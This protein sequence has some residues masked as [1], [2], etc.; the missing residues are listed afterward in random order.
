MNKV[1]DVLNCIRYN[2]EVDFDTIVKIT[3]INKD[4]VK[5]TLF[6]LLSSNVIISNGEKYSLSP[7]FCNKEKVIQDTFFNIDILEEHKQKIYYL[8][9]TIEKYWLKY[10][11]SKPKRTQMY[12]LIVEVNK[13]LNLGLPVVWYKFGQVVPVIF[14][15]ERDYSDYNKILVGNMDESKIGEIVNQNQRY[16]SNEMRDN[17]YKS[18]EDGLY[19]V[20]QTKR[21]MEKRLMNNDFKYLEDNFNIYFEKVPYFK[22]DNKTIDRFYELT[23]DYNQLDPKLQKDS[24]FKTI[25]LKAFELFWSVVAI[26]NFK[27]DLWQYYSNNQIKKERIDNCDLDLIKLKDEFNDIRDMFYT[28]FMKEKYKDDPIYKKLMEN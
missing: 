26:N 12:K 7:G 25:Y 23:Q 1:V 4:T 3:E 19:K 5:K 13:K 15:Q 18:G 28:K 14:D 17:Q 21:E 9:Y 27:S 16:S 22:D 10:T 20:Y 6:E 11:K 2:P 8:F 24:E